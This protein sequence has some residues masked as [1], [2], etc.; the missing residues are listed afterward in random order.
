M[1]DPDDTRLQDCRHR[2]QE[3]ARRVAD[4]GFVRSGSLTRRLTRC[5]KPGCRCQADPPRLHGPYWQ[6]TAK[7]GGKTVT[8]RLTEDQ[9]RLYS[10]W[11]DNDRRLRALIT[12]MR[13]IADQA[14]ELILRQDEQQSQV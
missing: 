3:L 7:T 4:I 5:G 9:A 14:T 1:E 8:R 6:W 13:Q 12:Q 10:E 2:Y 11:I